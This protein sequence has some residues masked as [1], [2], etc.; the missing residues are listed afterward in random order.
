M[1]QKIVDSGIDPVVKDKIIGLLKTL[2]PTA[3]IYLY[4][5]RARGTHA[6]SSDVDIGIDN[7]QKI[8]LLKVFEANQLM[9]ALV[10]PLKIEVVDLHAIPEAMKKLVDKDKVLWK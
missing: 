1:S 2:F 7:G 8:D 4:G 5:S 9:E 3:S 10:T 6:R